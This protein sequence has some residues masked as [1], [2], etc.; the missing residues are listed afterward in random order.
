MCTFECVMIIILPYSWKY[1]RALNL[2]VEPQIAIRRILADLNFGG[3]VR[4]RHTYI[5]E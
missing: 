3:S 2:A 4:D 5:C 1:W